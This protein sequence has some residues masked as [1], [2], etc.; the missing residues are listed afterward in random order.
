MNY[1]VGSCREVGGGLW[2]MWR[3]IVISADCSA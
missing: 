3:A 1:K 2:T